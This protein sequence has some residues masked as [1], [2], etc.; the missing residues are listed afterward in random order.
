VPVTYGETPRVLV[1]DVADS[2]ALSGPAVEGLRLLGHAEERARYA[3]T[4]LGAG[5]LGGA[6]RSVRQAVAVTRSRP[7]R[8]RAA[9]FPPSVLRRW[10]Q[11]LGSG[12]VALS[13]RMSYLQEV[14]V[15]RLTPR[16]LLP[17]RGTR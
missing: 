4:P 8:L 3:R 7:V 16:R 11:R 17:R 14:V 15:E 1:Y 12:S 10:R 6:L 9:L 2:L 13:G 5:D